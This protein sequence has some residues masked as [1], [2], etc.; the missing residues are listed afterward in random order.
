MKVLTRISFTA[1]LFFVLVHDNYAQKSW[2]KD[3]KQLKKDEVYKILNDSPWAK[4]FTNIDVSYSYTG[5]NKGAFDSTRLVAAPPLIVRFYSS[6]RIRQALLR[7]RQLQVNYDNLTDVQKAEFD[8]KNK[9]VLKCD[10]CKNYYVFIL[11]QPVSNPNEKSIIGNHFK[12]NK[13]SDF[14]DTI[15][16]TN[17]RK[18]KRELEEFV[19]PKTDA[20]VAVFYF[21]VMDE[22][23]NPLITEQTK[24]ITLNFKSS[25]M[26]TPYLQNIE[27]DVTK[28]MINGKF[29]F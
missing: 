7:L 22:K 15:F 10:N 14:K 29:D 13:V 5:L 28:M 8:E 20:D 2:E 25:L 16:L 3:W 12:D 17:D 11:L 26:K 4:N 9:T 23:Q 24:K 1:L 21:P 6:L 18:E 19:A 27:F